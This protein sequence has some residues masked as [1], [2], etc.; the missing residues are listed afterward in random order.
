V[1]II[2]VRG[3]YDY[4]ALEFE[5]NFSEEEYKKL[6]DRAMKNKGNKMVI[7]RIVEEGGIDEHEEEFHIRAYEFEDV[8]KEFVKFVRNEVQDYDS[9]KHE[10]FYIID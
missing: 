4:V 6:W 2:N 3:L 7:N 5:E 1:K 10:N 8:D 9:I